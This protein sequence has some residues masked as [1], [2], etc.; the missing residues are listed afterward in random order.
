M[1]TIEQ[2]KGM[3]NLVVNRLNGK[4]RSSRRR[5][6]GRGDMCCYVKDDHPGC[7]VGCQIIDIELKNKIREWEVA[8]EKSGGGNGS[9]YRVLVRELPE[10]LDVLNVST[11]DNYFMEALQGFHDD[12]DNWN[13]NGFLRS[14]AIEQFKNIHFV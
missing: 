11:D 6:D 10:V 5:I 1:M 9:A 14:E 12:V 3:F 2:K 8:K 13:S 4:G 7:A